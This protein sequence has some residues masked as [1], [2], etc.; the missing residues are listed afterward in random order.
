MEDLK[1]LNEEINEKSEEDKVIEADGDLAEN[2]EAK[3]ADETIEETS[4]KEASLLDISVNMTVG[5]MYDFLLQHTYRR[6]SGLIGSVFGALLIVMYFINPQRSGILPLICGVV[7][8]LYL[9]ITLFLKA[10][11]QVMVTPAFKKPLNYS[12][13]ES[14]V[15]ISQNDVTQ[16]QNWDQMVKAISTNRSIILYTSPVNASIFPKKDIGTDL[17][18]LIEIISTHMPPKKVNIR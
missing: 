12:F 5:V 18:S 8:L 1:K 13:T 9:P 3:S 10:K 2:S 7:V 6:T 14:G 4:E 16:K 17:M 15:E 11:T